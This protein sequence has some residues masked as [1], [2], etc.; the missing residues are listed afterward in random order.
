MGLRLILI[1]FFSV[2]L[3]GCASTIDSGQKQHAHLFNEE[4]L[5]VPFT[6][7]TNDENASIAITELM[8]NQLTQYGV[9]V[10]R[11]EEIGNAQQFLAISQ[12]TESEYLR[13]AKHKN[14]RYLILGAVIEYRYKV[15][16]DADP[17]VTITA[18]ILDSETGKTVWNGSANNTGIGFSSLGAV[19][20]EMIKDFT[21]RMPI[22]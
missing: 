22:L 16:L 21:R 4:I 7:A 6:N 5:L 15:D 3:M 19:S 1:M 8:D 13:I 9:Q 14:I 20:Q 18:R 12:K 17:T 10:E 11:F 2:L